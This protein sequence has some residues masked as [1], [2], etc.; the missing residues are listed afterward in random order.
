LRLAKPLRTAAGALLLLLSLAALAATPALALNPERHY[1]MVSPV[2]KGGFDVELLQAAGAN[3]ESVVFRSPGAFAGE[4]SGHDLSAY[5]AHRG[6]S[7]WSTEPFG[8]PAL[9]AP[10]IN[11]GPDLTP[12]MNLALD[13]GAKGFNPPEEDLLLHSTVSPGALD[14][15]EPAGTLRTVD[16]QSLF[17]SYDG[18]SAS[19]CHLLLDTKADEPLVAEA[20]GVREEGELYEFARGCDGEASSLALVGLNNKGGEPKLINRECSAALG[21]E[22]YAL[23]ASKFNAVSADGAEVFFTV[24]LS[25]ETVPGS[26]HQL[27]VRLG[28]SRTLEVSRPLGGCI[29]G[30]VPGEVPCDGAANRPSADFVGASEDGSTVYF[31]TSAALSADDNDSGNDL[32]MA[33]I[34]C[35]EAKPGCAVVEHEVTSLTQVSR[36]PTSGQ[37]ADVQ[38]VVRVAPDGSRVYFVAGGDLLSR[39]Q[40]EA[41]EGEGRPV[42]Q[43]GAANLYEYDRGASEATAFVGDLCSGQEH[44]GAVEDARCPSA[45]GSDQLLWAGGTES[46]AQTAGTDGN[47]LVFT[48]YAQLLATDTNRAR[49]VYRYDAATD[50]LTRVSGGENGYDA[51]GNREV[52]EN[53]EPLGASIAQ[54]HYGASLT[55]RNE[56]N[57]RAISED[58]SR[59]VFSSAE[60]L[61]PFARNGLENAYEWH[62]QPGDEGSVSLLSGGSGEQ[63]VKGLVISPSGNDV[64]F[65]TTQGLVPQDTDGQKDLYDARIGAGFPSPPA[66]A[67]PCSGDACQGPLTNPAALLV[68][69]SVSQAPGENLS[70]LTAPTVKPEPRPKAVKCKKGH[71]KRKRRCVKA[72]ARKKAK[73]ADRKESK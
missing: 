66:P 51:N 52:L 30:G 44:S 11:F 13:L 56:L 5:L 67:Q 65:I 59:I 37:A 20:V 29:A 7:S 36:D 35:P 18:A 41:L 69:G 6:A 47:F 15:W 24:C 53:G 63:P 49:D 19:F 54:G 28:G 55:E 14:G 39:A 16:E 46:H 9:L 12:S 73:K 48:T 43:L 50:L 17:A 58:G 40:Q 3:G 57:N 27:F 8:V 10:I 1:E 70:P 2:F 25:R 33:R 71:V 21:S 22:Y 26:P 72:R 60:P 38:G 23:A 32:Y 62:E 68:P 4:P 34:G 45:T 64:F 61:S 31:T 42:P